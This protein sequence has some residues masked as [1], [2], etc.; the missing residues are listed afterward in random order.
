[1]WFKYRD[2][3]AVSVSLDTKLNVTSSS[4]EMYSSTRRPRPPSVPIQEHVSP[5]GP[6]PGGMHQIWMHLPP[7]TKCEHRPDFLQTLLWEL[8]QHWPKRLAIDLWTFIALSFAGKPVLCE[9]KYRKNF[10][11]KPFQS[12]AHCSIFLRRVLRLSPNTFIWAPLWHHDPVSGVLCRGGSRAQSQSLNGFFGLPSGYSESVPCREQRYALLHGKFV[13][14]ALF[15]S[16]VR[17]LKIYWF[18]IICLWFKKPPSL[19]IPS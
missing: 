15:L 2:W 17:P 5:S 11:A 14:S 1:M 18:D 12:L 7:T 16:S 3:V 9:V 8:R 19:Q 6:H 4:M 13:P 10:M